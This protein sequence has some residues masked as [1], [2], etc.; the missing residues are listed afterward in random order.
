MSKKET[1]LVKKVEHLLKISNQR[2]Y[3]HRFGPKK[4]KLKNHLIALLLIEVCQLSLRRIEKFLILVGIKV[5]TYSALCKSRKRI[6][7]KLW[8]KLLKLTA[9]LSSGK[10]AIDG[11]GFS[12]TNPSF[13]Y[14]KRIDG[15]NPRN[16]TKLSA[17]LDLETKKFLMMRIRTTPR[18]DMQDVKYLLKRISDVKK[19]YGDSGYDAEWIHEMCYWFGVQTYIPPRRNV[20]IRKFRKKQ[21]EN[22]DKKEYNLRSNVEAG[23]SA[24]KRKY[25][26]SVRAKKIEGMRAEILLRG[27]AHNLELVG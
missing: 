17:L 21:M 23:F 4:Y 15:T 5:P 13:H 24:I 25:G 26:G 19:F 22:W 20:R 1:K 6:P 10:V 3:L 2:E 11:T 27:I 18:H 9:G 8:Q 12:K 16:Y 7:I 14:L